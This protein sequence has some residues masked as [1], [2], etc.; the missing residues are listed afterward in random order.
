MTSH[1]NS[2][3]LSGER[4]SKFQLLFPGVVHN[5]WVKALTFVFCYNQNIMIPTNKNVA[6]L[7]PY[8]DKK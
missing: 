4:G 1:L 7:H 2:L 6:V 8:L 5:F 3:S